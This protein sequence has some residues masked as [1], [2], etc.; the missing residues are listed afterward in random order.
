MGEPAGHRPFAAVHPQNVKRAVRRAAVETNY[1]AREITA[2]LEA[3]TLEQGLEPYVM[4][5]G[6]VADLARRARQLARGEQLAAAD[7]DTAL[8]RAAGAAV[9]EI[10]RLAD[11]IRARGAKSGEITRQTADLRELAKAGTEVARMLR[12]VRRA[13]LP[14]ATP[15]PDAPAAP[16]FIG[17]L[18]P[19]D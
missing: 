15:A 2:R 19:D 6:Y 13:Q 14:G 7:G 8:N 18:D 11:R 16:D 5:R 17:S 10:E 4:K 3:G 12:E 1:S 9:Q